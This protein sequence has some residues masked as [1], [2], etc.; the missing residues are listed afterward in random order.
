MLETELIARYPV[1]F[2]MAEAGGWPT[3]RKLG[4]LSTTAA[5]DRFEVQGSARH[6]LECAHRPEKIRLEHKSLGHL[7]LRDQK[8]MPAAR[9]SSCLEDD[10][11]PADWYR[12]LNAK[13]FF[14]ATRDRLITL[15]KARSY[16]N[17]EHDV[18]AVDT[19]SLLGAHAARMSLCHMNS[20]NAFRFARPRGRSTF[21]PI[22][23]YP[24][25]DGRPYKE[26]AEVT[27][28]YSVPDIVRHVIRVERMRQ[29]ELRQ[30]IWQR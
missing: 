4:L 8:P 21:M 1:L 29:E 30:V 11:S 14:W 6:A 10:L 27:V 16:R 7:V 12:I 19:A 17:E 2:H 5:L 9:L 15:L 25:R 13:T 20:G 3:I 28:E 22:R 18:L 26:V 24:A 23:T